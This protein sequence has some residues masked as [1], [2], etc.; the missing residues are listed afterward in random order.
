M[1][2]LL[3]IESFFISKQTIIKNKLKWKKI[4]KTKKKIYI[5]V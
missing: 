4:F 3:D 2:K 5:M 1:L